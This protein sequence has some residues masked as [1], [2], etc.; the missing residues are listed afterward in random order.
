MVGQFF[1]DLIMFENKEEVKHQVTDFVQ[2]KTEHEYECFVN[3]KNKGARYIR[4]RFS[5][6]RNQNSEIEYFI[7][8]GIDLTDRIEKEKNFKKLTAELNS[9]VLELETVNKE[10]QSFAYSVSHDLRTPLRTVKGFT[11]LIIEEYY[12]SLDELGRDYLQRVYSGIQKMDQLISDILNLTKISRKELKKE[13]VDLGA[14]ACEIFG[15]LCMSEPERKIEVL[16]QKGCKVT[17]DSNL[18][19]IVLN[20]LI[21]NAWKFTRK[22][23]NPRIEFG[24]RDDNGHTIY[25]IKDNGAGFDMA[26]AQDIFQPFKRLH[27]ESEFSGT[28][29]GLAIVEKVIKKHGGKIWAESQSGFGATFFFTIPDKSI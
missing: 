10:L 12:E 23:D 29:I 27:L 5:M 21:G 28:G 1:W 24:S 7:I 15:E 22:K 18:L 19:K 16:V 8:S 2:K 20:N 13:A 25:F 26:K 14:L 17:G 3:V 6:L 9:R 4:W 11:Q